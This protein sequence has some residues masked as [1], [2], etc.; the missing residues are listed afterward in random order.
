ME[1]KPLLYRLLRPVACAVMTLVFSPTVIHK[2]ALPRSGAFVLAGN[3]INAKDPVLIYTCTK[4][5]VRTLAKAELHSGKFGWLFKGVGSIP[6]HTKTVGD[7][8]AALSEAVACLKNGGII[9][10][11]PE[12]TRNKT[13]ALLLPFKPGA[14]VMAQRAACPIIPYAIMGDYT[15]RSRSLRIVFGEPI[16]VTALSVEEGTDRLY[17]AVEQLLITHRASSR[18]EETI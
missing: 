14:V 5:L 11:S 15:F 3:H 7:N 10:V 9:N 13:T 4:R 16:D 2:E 17:H 8:H 12:G 18:K 1:Q 6:V